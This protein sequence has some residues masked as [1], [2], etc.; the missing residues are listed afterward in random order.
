MRNVSRPAA[1]TVWLA[2]HPINAAELKAIAERA[3]VARWN[4]RSDEMTESAK[5]LLNSLLFEEGRELVNIKFF[6]GSNRGLTSEQL[7]GATASAIRSA[8]DK[9]PL[10]NPPRT[11][12][13][14]LT[15]D[16]FL[17]SK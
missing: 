7:A 5:T 10:N 9:G 4:K 11:G 16:A 2:R 14:K 6:P 3:V 1:R 8:I 13:E 12:A 15:L 17:A